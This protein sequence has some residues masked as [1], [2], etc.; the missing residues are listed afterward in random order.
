MPGQ[1]RSGEWILVDPAVYTPPTVY[2]NRERIMQGS[3]SVVRLS[4]RVRWV[5]VRLH[6]TSHD[7]P[8]KNS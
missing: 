5:D 4:C 1:W 7:S 3:D 2:Y 8:A 6:R